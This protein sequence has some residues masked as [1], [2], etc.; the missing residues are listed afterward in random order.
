MLPSRLSVKLPLLGLILNLKLFFP[1]C[2]TL[3]ISSLTVPAL[4]TF[5]VCCPKLSVSVLGVVPLFCW[6]QYKVAPLG[7][8]VIA[9]SLPAGNVSFICVVLF[10]FIIMFFVIVP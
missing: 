1:F 3:I 2:T 10:S 9:I 6:S 7:S 8:L 4:S 5:I